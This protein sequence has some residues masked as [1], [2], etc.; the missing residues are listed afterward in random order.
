MHQSQ[1]NKVEKR[2]TILS[3]CLYITKTASIAYYFVFFIGTLVFWIQ[4]VY[5]YFF[6]NIRE[7]IFVFYLPFFD[8]ETF[9]G[10]MINLVYQLFVEYIAVFFGG[11]FDTLFG[12]FVLHSIVYS[13]LF[14]MDL[15]ELEVFLVKNQ[16]DDQELIKNKMR[17]IVLKH[18]EIEE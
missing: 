16:Y 10:Y 7:L 4:P 15:D 18:K 6:N 5:S 14:K 3:T 13:D 12:L 11:S 9:S 2:K 1:N 8:H 17:D